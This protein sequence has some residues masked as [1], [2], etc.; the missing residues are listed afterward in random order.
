MTASIRVSILLFYRR[1]FAKAHALMSNL[2]WILLGAQGLYVVVFCILPGFCCRPMHM[3]W[4]PVEQGKY[5]NDEYI[6]KSQ[7]GLYSV[8]LIFDVF[9]LVMPLVPIFKLQMP[10]GRRLGVAA[11]FVLGAS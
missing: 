10:L 2:I 11:I 1:M 5:C 9:L 8:S 6:Y 3:A 7:V 4:N